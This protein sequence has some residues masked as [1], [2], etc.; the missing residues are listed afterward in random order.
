MKGTSK[1]SYKTKVQ[2]V[3]VTTNRTSRPFSIWVINRSP[4]VATVAASNI[5][6]SST[7]LME[8]ELQPFMGLVAMNR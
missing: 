5:S 7:L 8:V 6:A 4:A 3:K 1:K 2:E